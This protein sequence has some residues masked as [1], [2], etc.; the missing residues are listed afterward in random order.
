MSDKIDIRAETWK[1]MVAQNRADKKRIAQLEA[2]LATAKEQIAALTA[3]NP[4]A[5]KSE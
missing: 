2:D 3:R 4:G 5:A 1:K